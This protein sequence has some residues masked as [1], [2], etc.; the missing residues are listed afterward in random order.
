M[1]Y[2]TQQQRDNAIEARDVMWPSVPPENVSPNLDCYRDDD[3]GTP[4]VCNTL[5]CF[6]GWCAWWPSYQEQS[7]AAGKYGQ[8]TMAGIAPPDAACK[9]LFGIHG[10]FDRRGYVG[11]DRGFLGTDHELVTHRLNWLI[12]NSEVV[13]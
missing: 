7:V 2:V 1:I 13:A 5:A 12:E 3:N 10:L 11:S 4:P 8:P 9:C 6:G